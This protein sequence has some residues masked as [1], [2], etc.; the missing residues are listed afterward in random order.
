MEDRVRASEVHVGDG[1]AGP[2]GSGHTIAKRV[3]V[4]GHWSR[5]VVDAVRTRQ[6]LANVHHAPRSPACTHR[7]S[8]AIAHAFLQSPALLHVVVGVPRI[9][10]CDAKVCMRT[11]FT[12]G[13]NRNYFGQIVRT[14]NKQSTRLCV[15]SG[16]NRKYVVQAVLL[17]V[18][19][20]ERKV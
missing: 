14:S 9:P 2:S 16:Y 20:K 7:P 13:N 11:L 8:P 12:S 19:C 18:L 1:V 5:G 4:E 6:V 17:V 15:T 3:D 10:H